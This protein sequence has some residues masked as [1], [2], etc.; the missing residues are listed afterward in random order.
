[1]AICFGSTIILLFSTI[2]C[3]KL[4][5]S[6]I[7]RDDK[8]K[9]LIRINS[10]VFNET[11]RVHTKYEA[12]ALCIRRKSAVFH[13]VWFYPGFLTHSTLRQNDSSLIFSHESFLG[14]I[15]VSLLVLTPQTFEACK[16]NIFF[17]LLA[18]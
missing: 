4:M 17:I 6:I 14:M 8:F 13:L 7:I 5:S 16:F 9:T 3:T 18:V 1:M 2:K 10:K 11:S 15:N 12:H